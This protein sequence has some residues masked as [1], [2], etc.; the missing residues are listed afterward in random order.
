M[1]SY[2]TIIVEKKNGVMKITLNRP[3]VLNA[4]NTELIT[5]LGHALED[6]D[7]DSS[8]RV[9]VITGAGDRAFSAG[10]DIS[11]FMELKSMVEAR[12]FAKHGFE[13]VLKR[14]ESIS[15]PVIAMVNGL[16]LGGGCELAMACDIIIASDKA[17]FGQPE[18]NVGVLPG[19]GGMSRL[20]RLVGIHK[21]KELAF[22]GNL[23]TASEAER[24]GLVNKVVQSE[25]LEEE[26]MGIANRLKEKSPIALRFA[27]ETINRS[28]APDIDDVVMRDVDAFAI[29]FTTED[30][31]E[32]IKA[33]LEKRKP[34]FKGK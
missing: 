29:M 13:T 24:I 32:G 17:M 4:I 28:F 9:I 14:I 27:K 18:I 19:W 7:K 22:T 23:I 1:N 3:K 31:K 21:A 5:D 15:K 33:F 11:S 30:S 2:K 6:A 25:K 10:A 26:V 8:V 34:E 12:E 20:A 16:A